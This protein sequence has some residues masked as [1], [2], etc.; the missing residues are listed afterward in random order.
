M[1]LFLLLPINDTQQ[2]NLSHQLIVFRWDAINNLTYYVY[3]KYFTNSVRF[4]LLVM[5]SMTK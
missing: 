5:L 4:K 3:Y 1:F 2:N